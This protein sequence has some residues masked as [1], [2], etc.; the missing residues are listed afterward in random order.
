CQDIF[1]CVLSGEKG[2]D[3]FVPPALVAD[4]ALQVAPVIDALKARLPAWL[5]G[6]RT[7]VLDGNHL[8]ATERR[9]SELRQTWAAAL[10]GKVLAVYEQEVD[11][12]T[13]VFLTPDGHAQERSLL[14]DVL[15]SVQAKDLW[16]ADR[17]F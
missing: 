1:P 4:S 13:Q 12:V 14:D 11:L 5:P 16:I 8:S 17:N 15:H 3:P 10:P 7:R 2:P 9:I 6:F